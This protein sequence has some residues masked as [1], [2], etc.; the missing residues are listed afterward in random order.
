MDITVSN[1]ISYILV[2]AGGTLSLDVAGWQQIDAARVEIIRIIHA[3]RIY[4]I[5]F[6]CRGLSGQLSTTNRF[7]LAM[8]FVKENI[9]FV[10]EHLPSLKIALVA[11]PSMRDPQKI[12]EKVARNRGLYGFITAELDTAVNWLGENGTP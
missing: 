5:L 1:Q 7:L 2:T 6:D 10:A 8:V 3:A 12:G 4:K 11:D 9:R